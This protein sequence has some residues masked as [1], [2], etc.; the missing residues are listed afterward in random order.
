MTYAAL[1]ERVE[2]IARA[3]HSR[4]PDQRCEQPVVGVFQT[5]SAD[6]IA[7]LVAI[8][9][10][11]AI[12]LPLDLKVST[13]R[14]ES[15]VEATRLAAILVGDYMAVLAG[16]IGVEEEEEGQGPPMSIINISGPPP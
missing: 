4:L 16:E 8:H 5:P 10:V 3:L 11:S 13:A 7:S 15:Y 6:W 14:L 1:D 9:R 12:Y 2:S